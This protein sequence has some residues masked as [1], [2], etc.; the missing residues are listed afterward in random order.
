MPNRRHAIIWTNADPIH[1]RTYAALGWDE[2][3]GRSFALGFIVSGVLMM[4]NHANAV[5]PHWLDH[6]HCLSNRV[7]SNKWSHR[8]GV[9]KP[10]VRHLR[11]QELPMPPTLNFSSNLQCNTQ[12]YIMVDH[13]R[14]T[15]FLRDGLMDSMVKRRLVGRETGVQLLVERHSLKFFH[16]KNIVKVL[17]PTMYSHFRVFELLKFQNS[18]N[19]GN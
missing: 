7:F 4:I 1:W 6:V 9:L 12:M 18:C 16:Q 11:I 5:P 3:K 8:V 2:L 17:L 14:T 15:N 19:R 10:R 13:H